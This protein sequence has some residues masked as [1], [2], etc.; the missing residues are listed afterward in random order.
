MP[1]I[2]SEPNRETTHRVSGIEF[3]GAADFDGVFVDNVF[4]GFGIALTIVHVPAE[5]FEH[6]VD[7]LAADLGFV[8]LAGEVCVAVSVEPVDEIGDGL[9]Q[10]HFGRSPNSKRRGC[11]WG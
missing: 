2:V 3:G 5:R 6:G 7:K 8:V 1:T 9:G 4:V 11:L 10:G